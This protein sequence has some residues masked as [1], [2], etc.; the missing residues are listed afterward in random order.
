MFILLPFYIT[1]TQI[2]GLFYKD[3]GLYYTFI[4]KQGVTF[5]FL[6]F[7]ETEYE[8]NCCWCHYYCLVVSLINVQI[9]SKLALGMQTI[10][11]V[12]AQLIP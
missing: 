9:E 2:Y 7:K 11:M 10:K 4:Y 5:N 8:N 3:K 1:Y 12:W 6:K